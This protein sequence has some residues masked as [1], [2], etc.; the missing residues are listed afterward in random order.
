MEFLS[1]LFGIGSRGAV[2]RTRRR[3]PCSSSSNVCLTRSEKRL[4]RARKVERLHESTCQKEE[5][6]LESPRKQS[7]PSIAGRDRSALEEARALLGSGRSA[8]PER[9]PGARLLRD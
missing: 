2:T 5:V 7:Q 3:R 6:R 8:S 1:Q 4:L 9:A